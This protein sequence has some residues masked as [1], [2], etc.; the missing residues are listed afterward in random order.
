MEQLIPFNPVGYPPRQSG[1]TGFRTDPK[2]NVAYQDNR[3]NI[4]TLYPAFADPTQ[5]LSTFKSLDAKVSLTNNDD[6]T[7]TATF[8]GK[9]YSLVPDYILTATPP[10]HTN[11]AWWQDAGG[12]VYIKNSG[13]V[14]AQG[15][16]VK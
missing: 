3:G 4:Q 10:T 8:L 16:V 15:F 6:G 14:S 5:L 11:D 9:P 7:A 13:G 1:A 2:G 12:K